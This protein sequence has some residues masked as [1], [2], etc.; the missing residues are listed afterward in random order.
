MRDTLL[1][2]PK[3][4]ILD[5][6]KL[7]NGGA[8][9]FDHERLK[10]TECVDKLLQDFSPDRVQAAV[11]TICFSPAIKAGVAAAVQTS[12]APAAPAASTSSVDQDA[13]ARQIGSL[14]ASLAGSAVN[15]QRVR[16]IVQAEVTSA[17]ERSPVVT[18]EVKRPD[19]SAVKVDGHTRPEFQ[20]VLMMAS[21]GLNILLVGAAGCGKTHLA[22]QVAEALGRPFA[23]ISCTAG[24]SESQ[25][26]GWLLP[27]EGGAFEYVPSDF[28]TM[29]ENG[30][31]FLFDEVDAA[32]PNTLLF[33]NQALANGS[34]YLPQRKGRTQVKRHSDFVCIAAANTF[35]TGANM[36]YAGRERLD[37]STLDRFRAGTVL[38]DYDTKFE[39]GVVDP[40]VL[41]WGWAVRKKISDL[42]LSRVMSTRF[43]LDATK[44][45][46]A[47]RSLE[48]IKST[49]FTGWK[50]DE[51]QKVEV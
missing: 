8:V 1:Q 27:S 7:L 51:R 10:K 46:K 6:F 3:A 34:F 44:L 2:L 4:T 35:G 19:G 39:R 38:L 42:R 26:T 29:Y 33:I 43:L 36:V 49:Y 18:I 17:I 23:S 48:Q 45:V 24:M 30:G 15:E 28:V 31:V 14:F 50:A 9:G 40:E 11:D 25:L 5:L 22:H 37:E 41:A 20:D 16:E 32:D 47:G 12:S 13:V 21:V